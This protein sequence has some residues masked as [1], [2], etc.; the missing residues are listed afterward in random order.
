M[1]TV[2]GEGGRGGIISAAMTT[3]QQQSRGRNTGQAR[4]RPMGSACQRTPT[5]WQAGKAPVAASC[6]PLLPGICLPA[7]CPQQRPP[8]VASAPASTCPTKPSCNY[9]PHC[10]TGQKASRDL[11]TWLGIGLS[12]W[13]G[14]VPSSCKHISILCIPK[15]N[16]DCALNSCD[17]INLQ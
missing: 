2:A 13:A 9:R 7:F 4:S 14:N 3:W 10:S 12:S 1:E 6:V 17:P 11:Q 5:W 16:V 8:A 15:C